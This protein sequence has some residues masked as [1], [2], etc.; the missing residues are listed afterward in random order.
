MRSRDDLNQGARLERSYTLQMTQVLTKEEVERRIFD[1]LAPLVG[2]DVVPGSIGRD[3]PPAPDIELCQAAFAPRPR[4]HEARERGGKVRFFIVQF[5][6]GIVSS[7]GKSRRAVCLDRLL[8]APALAPIRGA[9][10]AP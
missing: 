10:C 4:C 3:K 6:A 1:A 9:Q 8:E 2:A 7:Q 5:T